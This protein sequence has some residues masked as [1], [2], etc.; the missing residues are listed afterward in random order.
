ME[1][2]ERQ[3][4]NF[5]GAFRADVLIVQVSDLLF[6]WRGQR[7]GVA[8]ELVRADYHAVCHV[9]SKWGDVCVCVCLCLCL[10]MRL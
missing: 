4:F 3:T 7:C 10:C 5:L 6:L 8:G 2:W 9:G 1:S